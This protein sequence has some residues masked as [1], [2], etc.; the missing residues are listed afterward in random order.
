MP[1]YD[2]RQVRPGTGFARSRDGGDYYLQS[3][4]AAIASQPDWIVINSFNEWPEGT[5]IEPSQAHGSLY[6]D[7]TREWSARFKG[8]DFSS[9]P[10]AGTAK[11]AQAAATAL[12]P[13]PT[14]APELASTPLPS[15]QIQPGNQAAPA[16]PMEPG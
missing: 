15:L 8:A 12:P 13:T 2:D 11:A 3:W 16:G 9:R 1:G 5:Y 14:P 10:S 6:L 4:Q 7:L